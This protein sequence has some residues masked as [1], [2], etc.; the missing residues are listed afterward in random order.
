MAVAE[1]RRSIAV[2]MCTYMGQDY[3]SQQL[4]SIL[5]QVL[6]PDRIYIYDDQSSDAT[7]RVIEAYLRRFPGIIC[8]LTDGVHRGINGAVWYSLSQVKEDMVFLCD[9]DDLWHPDKI[10]RM[11]DFVENQAEW[12]RIPCIL[13][14]ESMLYQD[15][16]ETGTV[17]SQL[18]G[19]RTGQITVEDLLSRNLVQ[20]CTMLINRPLIQMFCQERLDELF[21]HCIYDQ[22][23]ALI[24]SVFGRIYFLDESLV[25]YRI[26]GKNVVG[27]TQ[28]NI[29]EKYAL[30][31]NRKIAC[32]FLESF[33]DILS[34]EVAGRIRFWID[35]GYRIITVRNLPL[36]VKKGAMALCMGIKN[37]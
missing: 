7:I 5:S 27:S 24:A 25:Y 12:D 3:L 23:M 28:V 15:E 30:S 9:Q 32:E 13:H 20:G 34:S 11:V 29:Y 14:S 10:R 17:L 36:L 33:R 4:D 19:R 37:H 22:W 35:K 21:P 6:V 16:K 1:T 2:V 26:H 18:I 8:S 31:R